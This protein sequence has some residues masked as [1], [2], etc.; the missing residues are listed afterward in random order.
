[1][2]RLSQPTSI[3]KLSAVFITV[4]AIA[5]V[6]V[7]WR[8]P[9]DCINPCKSSF[10]V[11]AGLSRHQNDCVIHR[12]SQALKQ[13]QRRVRQA[14]LSSSKI[15]RPAGKNL[16]RRKSRIDIMNSHVSGTSILSVFDRLIASSTT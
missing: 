11:R 13:E 5:I 6:N 1:M 9:F 16:E 15:S 7:V 14:L 8:M 2:A 10:S 3:R 12:T 4:I